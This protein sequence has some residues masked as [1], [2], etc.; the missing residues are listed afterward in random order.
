MVLS[1]KETKMG[2]VANRKRKE[3]FEELRK[4]G[5][6]ARIERQQGNCCL[7]KYKRKLPDHFRKC[8]DCPLDS[9]GDM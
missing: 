1:G 8:I 6:E 5:E 2:K 9:N 4:R 3:F 7:L